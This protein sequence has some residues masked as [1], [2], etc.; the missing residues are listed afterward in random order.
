[1]NGHVT[2]VADGGERAG[3][4][5]LGRSSAIAAALRARGAAVSC[6][7]YGARDTR[8]IDG[9]EWTPLHEPLDPPGEIVVL[10][11]YTMP[12]A[13]QAALARRCSL[14]VM[15]DQGGV[16]PGTALVVS[17]G[18][19]SGPDGASDPKRLEG[20]RY[21][22]LRAPFW[23]VAERVVRERAGRVLVTTG[24][25]ALQDAGVTLAGAIKAAL[26]EHAVAL[27][28]GP[29]AH[30]EA[31]PGVELVDAPPS[32]LDE[33]LA[34]DVVVTA[35]GQTA[36]EAAATGVATV[37]LA[38]VPNQRGNASALEAAGAALVPDPGDAPAATAELA[39]DYAAR[40]ALARAGQAAVDGFGALRIAF[41]VATLR[42]F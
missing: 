38:L 9:V 25:G 30:F 13:D 39:G 28:R 26:P 8:A 1:V 10:D 16:P 23:G 17:A 32:L 20:L 14:A 19:T 36:L 18:S 33:L 15:H 27:V 29:L 24:G 34:A 21:A 42:S 35:A 40:V 3:L 22:P 31:P 5:H 6:R 2:L 4:G 7:A 12:A 37:A 41:R 11:T